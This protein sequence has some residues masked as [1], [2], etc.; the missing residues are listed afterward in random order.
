MNKKA[1]AI[2]Y[3]IIS[4]FS[5]ACMNACIRLSGDLPVIQKA[6]F[7]NL[8]AAIIAFIILIKSGEGMHYEKRHIPMLFLRAICGTLGIMCN[9]YAVDHMNISDASLLN[10]LS[11]FAAVIFS[12][13]MLK[14]KVNL[15]Q[16][17][18]LIIVF[19]GALFV[20]KPTLDF[21]EFAPGLIGLIGGI[22]AG[23]AY[24]AVRYLG[25][26]GAK[27]PQIVFFFSAFS[28]IVMLPYLLIYY[29][30]MSI[31]QFVILML[32]GVF[33]AAGQFSITAAYS[34]APAKEISIFDYTQIIFSA[35]LGFA[36]FE[37]IPDI[38]SILGYIIILSVT[39]Y[40]WVKNMKE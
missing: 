14:E 27:S 10:K 18:S 21:S 31:S 15:K 13:F 22:S 8:I 32:T 24:T 7:R 29:K 20:I 33:A 36:L 28:T 16:T 17:I 3:I 39:A 38:Y 9:F 40:T 30:P 5:F 4:A 19:T 37:Q 23:A 25:N 11:P 26:H 2:I 6:F 34:N 35:I 12:I 1:K